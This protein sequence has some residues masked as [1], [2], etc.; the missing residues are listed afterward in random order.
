MIRSI[1]FWI[2]IEVLS[3]SACNSGTDSDTGQVGVA[4]IS[5]ASKPQSSTSGP[6]A[7]SATTSEVISNP[8]HELMTQTAPD[9][10]KVL[11]HTS[12]GDFVVQVNREWAPIGSER[13][14]NL[15][16]NKYYDQNYFFRVA[17]G[18]GADRFVVQWGIH[19]DPSINTAYQRSP[20]A[21]IKDDPVIRSNTRGRL[22]FATAGR[23]SR[24]TQLF[25]S[26]ADNN[27]LDGM[28]FAAFGEVIDGGMK[29]VEAINGEYAER[30]DQRQIQN[31]GNA[32]LKKNFPN[33]DYI[34]TATIV[35]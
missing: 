16:I 6:E 11:F 30:P 29:V 15:I 28:G 23:N 7:K 33:L 9:T 35:E 20:D 10:F 3:L 13:F 5:V 22:T 32:Y 2:L 17:P 18:R 4:G 34:I 26:Y 25:I 1:P 31:N 24:T 27:F 14:Y 21:K 8:A 12:A 19:G